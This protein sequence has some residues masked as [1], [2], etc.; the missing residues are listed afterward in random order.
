[1]QIPK[2]W[3]LSTAILSALAVGVVGYFVLQPPGALLS[4]TQF[5]PAR[6]TPNADGEDDITLFSYALSRPADVTLI[7]KD[8][9][10][11]EYIFRDTEPRVK[12]D[13]SV[14]FSGVVDGFQHEGET[15]EGSLERRLLP[16]GRYNWMLTAT[17]S[18]GEQETQ[19]GTLE[20]AEGDSALPLIEYF[21]VGPTVF[22]PNQ[23]GI[24]DRVDLNIFL[25][26]PAFLMVYL[27]DTN[28]IQYYISER[29]GGREPGEAGSHVFDYDGG[30]DQSM[31]PPANGNYT[32]Y[33]VAQDEVGQ[34]LVRTA[35]ITIQ[36]SGLPQ[37]E[38]I[39]QTTGGTVCFE[40]RPY[41]ESYFTDATTAGEKI[42]Q[43]TEVCSELTT[44]SVPF[45]DLLVF[46]LTVR[47]YG[48][49][50]IRTAGPFPGTVYDFNQV[51]ASL[52]AYNQS[53]VWRVGIMCETSQ[54]N[55]P[56]R[57]AV[58][59]SELLTAVYDEEEDVT[60]YYLEP[61]QRGEVWGA[62][63]LS[64]IVEARNPQPCWAGLIH[65]DVQIPSSQDNVGRR[66]IYIE[67]RP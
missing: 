6:I 3:I 40:T 49:T 7:F 50:P 1:M 33:A 15:W 59:P 4:E 64:E 45:G 10:G 56:W 47:N 2:L 36:D 62:V 9:R 13:Y 43:P 57:W 18:D 65:E 41:Q 61:G 63:R 66:E 60:Y 38:I 20:I 11:Q 30:V 24:D 46:H 67:P 22:T 35:E 42:S 51:P 39:P 19:T 27:E 17:D 53:G 52:G 12:G 34:R 31:R 25:S 26:K 44:L 14:E 48:D 55:Y 5:S 21:E 54:S 23:D 32:L 16:D 29:Q 37:V 8:D 28:G 58:A